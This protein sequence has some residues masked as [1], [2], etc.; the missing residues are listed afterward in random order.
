MYTKNCLYLEV[1]LMEGLNEDK[2][3]LA[4]PFCEYNSGGQG[5]ARFNL[6][7]EPFDFVLTL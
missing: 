1:W 3:A 2:G 5:F 7:E 4:A 6:V